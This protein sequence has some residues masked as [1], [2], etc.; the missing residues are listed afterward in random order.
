VTFGELARW[1]RGS[2]RVLVSTKILDLRSVRFRNPTKAVEKDFVVIHAPDWVNVVALTP[3]HH[4]VLVRQFRFGANAFSLEIPGG[5]I[6]K[7]EDPVT[8][9]TR[10]LL[11]ETGFGGGVASLIG[12][13]QPNPAIQDNRCHFVLI[14]GAVPTGPLNWDNDEEIE[15]STA[16]VADVLAWARSGKITHSLTVAALT[17][18]E[19]VRRI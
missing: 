1:E 6:E 5:M 14:D 4:L 9:G 17:F 2:E 7:G 12:S 8:A 3:E 19:G 15:T 10:E 18:L 13:V 11:E 16:P